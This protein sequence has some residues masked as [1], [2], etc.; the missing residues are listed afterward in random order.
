MVTE[1]AIDEARPCRTTRR[2]TRRIGPRI[3]V[4]HVKLN[5]TCGNYRGCE[6]GHSGEPQLIARIS[7]WGGWACVQPDVSDT[8]RALCATGR[9]RQRRLVQGDLRRPRY[10]PR[11]ILGID[12]GLASTGWALVERH[13]SRIGVVGSGTLRTSPRTPHAERL[14]ALFDGVAG[15][16]CDR[17]VAAAAVESWFIHPVSK[18]AMGMAE[19]R[20]AVIVAIATAGIE[21]VEYPPTEIKLAVTGNGRAGKDQVRAMVTRLT[22]HAA[23]GDHAADAIAA[24]VCF[25]H[26]EPLRA[27]IRKAQ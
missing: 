26:R 2:R 16:M 15:I 12:P 20:G 25:L 24:A 13:G 3:G 1:E 11:V 10:A 18:A 8:E 14:R 6:G 19:A 4:G 27:A 23:D 9:G 7:S 22:G 21:V 17:P 5:A